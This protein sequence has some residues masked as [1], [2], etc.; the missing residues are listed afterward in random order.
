MPYFPFL[1]TFDSGTVL[2]QSSAR[3]VSAVLG[4]LQRT[5][6]F[7]NDKGMAFE[8]LWRLGRWPWS[9]RAGARDAAEL[10]R[11][12]ENGMETGAVGRGVPVHGARTCSPHTALDLWSPGSRALIRGTDSMHYGVVH[13]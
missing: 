9:K 13:R 11:R 7:P 2:R 8:G 6:R 3:S 12:C 4:A 1:F 10:D 5:P